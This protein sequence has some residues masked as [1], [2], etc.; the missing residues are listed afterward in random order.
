[1]ILW[2]RVEIVERVAQACGKSAW[3]VCHENMTF[4]LALLLAQDVGDIEQT[5]MALLINASE[6]FKSCSLRELVR[7]EK[8]TLAT[9][10]LKAAGDADQEN[11]EPVCAFERKFW[12]KKL[13]N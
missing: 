7:P 4:I 5:T 1:M 13:D 6:N 9:E 3:F 10:L 2:K 8:I 11:K 12:L